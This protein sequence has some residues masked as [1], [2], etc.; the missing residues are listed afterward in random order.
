[1]VLLGVL[2]GLIC[3]L[4]AGALTLEALR[5]TLEPTDPPPMMGLFFTALA[6]ML[7]STSIFGLI[8]LPARVRSRGWWRVC[9]P[10]DLE[11]VPMRS[12]RGLLCLLMLGS[13]LVVVVAGFSVEYGWV[14]AV[15]LLAG[16]VVVPLGGWV[17]WRWWRRA[18][19]DDEAVGPGRRLTLHGP[20]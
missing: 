20:H 4:I 10:E 3:A 6:V 15:L 16:T 2:A 17:L 9:P 13:F 11:P 1:V 7:L 8:D 12:G 14:G 19:W 18:T 5:G